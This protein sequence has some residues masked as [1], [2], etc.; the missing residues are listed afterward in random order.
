MPAKKRPARLSPED[1]DLFRRA[2]DRARPLEQDRIV[3]RTPPRPPVPDQA[4]KD[5]REVMESLLS[6]DYDPAEIE[7]GDELAFVR[8]G[9]QQRVWRKLRRGQYV[10]QAQLDLHGRIVPEAREL[11]SSFLRD[12]CASGKR[13]VRIIHG[14]GLS[15]EGK[16]PVL[17]GKVN[18]WLRQRDEVLAFC[19]APRS[20]GGTGVVYVLLKRG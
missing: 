3:R 10:I 20:D 8:P 5:E 12:A 17:K 13:C 6:D 11:V 19:S 14:K 7:T 18:S 15:S 2:A 1:R 9:V 4:R 16:L